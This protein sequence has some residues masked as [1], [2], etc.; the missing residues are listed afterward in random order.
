ME[1]EPMAMASRRDEHYLGSDPLN[2]DTDAMGHRQQEL[3]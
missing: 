1:T 3:I 2:A